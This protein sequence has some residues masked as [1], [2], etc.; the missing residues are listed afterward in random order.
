M[1]LKA[2]FDNHPVVW[3][4][5]LIA[6]GFAAG[7]GARAYVLPV[8]AVTRTC[9]IEGLSSLEAAHAKE[10]EILNAK[11]VENEAQAASHQLI[12]AY[13]EKYLGYSVASA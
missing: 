2:A 8:S 1:S 4:L 5:G 10:L 13:Q 6:A 12:D 7:F 3:G 11:L 9:A